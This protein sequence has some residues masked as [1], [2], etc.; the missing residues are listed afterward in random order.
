MMCT[1]GAKAQEAY[2]VYSSYETT[3]TFCYDNERSSREGTTYD[4]NPELVNPAW[5]TDR[6]NDKVTQVVFDE[7]FANVNPKSTYHWFYEMRV[8]ESITGMNHLNTS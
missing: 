8:L 5:V 2:A 7:S 3:L 4:L 1:L 6:T